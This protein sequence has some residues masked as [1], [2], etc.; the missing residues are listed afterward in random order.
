[1]NLNE[2]SF[3]LQ[4]S[5]HILCGTAQNLRKELLDIVFFTF[6]INL[7]INFKASERNFVS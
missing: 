2:L 3:S 7:G 4:L 6:E 5:S 1:M